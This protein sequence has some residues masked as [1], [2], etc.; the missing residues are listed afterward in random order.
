M[1]KILIIEDDEAFA[2][3]LAKILSTQYLPSH[4]QSG[5]E[6]IKLALNDKP[7]LILIDINM[8]E[9]NGFSV[10]EELRGK[11]A[12]RDIPIII[13]TGEAEPLSRVKG[14]DAGADDYVS[15]PFHA[16][17][18]LARIRARLRRRA[19]ERKE[20]AEYKIGNLRYDPKS[21]QV[22][23]ND[24]VV[25][26][27]QVELQVLKYFFDYPNELI[28][29]ER[30]LGDLWPASVVTHRTVDTHVAHLRKKLKDSTLK[31][32]TVFRGGYILEI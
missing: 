24:E 20:N 14:L 15:K 16:Q 12:T 9:M 18:L 6:G 28:S 29:R 30:L 1:K 25:P 10:C 21:S 2:G 19:L 5:M 8:P 3:A 31:L 22:L 11:P 17:E 26:L 27:T 7:D 4:A 23:V 13:L 32:K